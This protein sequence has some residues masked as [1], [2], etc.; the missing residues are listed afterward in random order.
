MQEVIFKFP[1]LCPPLPASHTHTHTHAHTHAHTHC[2]SLILR[3]CGAIFG[4]GLTWRFSV[5]QILDPPEATVPPLAPRPQLRHGWEPQLRHLRHCITGTDL[6][7]WLTLTS[8]K[9]SGFGYPGPWPSPAMSVPMAC[10]IVVW[11]PSRVKSSVR[12]LWIFSRTL[13]WVCIN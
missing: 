8:W 2:S 4:G 9:L 3:S 7:T 13:T 6:V 10:H 12:L 11:I 1:R 5:S